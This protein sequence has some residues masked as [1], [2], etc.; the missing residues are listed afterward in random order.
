MGKSLGNVLE[1]TSLLMAYGADAVRFYFLK[2]IVFGQVLASGL[3]LQP[4]RANHLLGIER[5]DCICPMLHLRWCSHVL[6][7]HVIS[8]LRKAATRP[9]RPR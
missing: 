5:R 6:G 4:C 2:E 1:P 7:K 9:E 8:F 3:L